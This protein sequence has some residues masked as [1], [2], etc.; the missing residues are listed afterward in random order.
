VC[1]NHWVGM[2]RLLDCRSGPS[3]TLPKELDLIEDHDHLS[4]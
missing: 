4:F 2:T 1:V 3:L